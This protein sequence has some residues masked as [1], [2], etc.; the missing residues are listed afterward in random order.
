MKHLFYVYSNLHALIAYQIIE[1]NKIANDDIYFITYRNTQIISNYSSRILK[2]EGTSGFKNKLFSA[3]FKDERLSFLSNN[4]IKAYL[5]FT[6]GLPTGFFKNYDLLEEGIDIINDIEIK[7]PLKHIIKDLFNGII[8]LFVSYIFLWNRNQNL[9]NYVRGPIIFHLKPIIF[10]HP[11]SFYCISKNPNFKYKGELNFKHLKIKNKYSNDFEIPKN[12]NILVL[13]PLHN[14]NFRHNLLDKIFLT[15]SNKIKG[16]K[17]YVQFHPTDTINTEYNNYTIETLK[18][19]SSNFEIINISLDILC[20]QDL[21]LKLY[22][23][24]SSILFYCSRFGNNKAY[25]LGIKL[26]R[27]DKKFLLHLSSLWGDIS[28]YEKKLKENNINI[29]D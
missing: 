9:I 13:D 19:Y 12:S 11:K 6:Y 2:L 24:S 3:F 7:Y 14:K 21:E 18:N 17:F 29:I 26:A 10:K 5:P 8:F 22:G 25:S 23:I 16:E 15:F 20:L 28:I 27:L 1:E 4:E